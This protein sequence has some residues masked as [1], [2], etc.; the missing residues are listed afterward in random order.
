MWNYQS[1]PLVLRLIC[2]SQSLGPAPDVPEKILQTFPGAGSGHLRWRF[3]HFG[4]SLGQSCWGAVHAE[5]KTGSTGS[6][7]IFNFLSPQRT[8]LIS[9]SNS[10][11]NWLVFHNFQIDIVAEGPRVTAIACQEDQ[12]GVSWLLTESLQVTSSSVADSLFCDQ[13]SQGQRLWQKNWMERIQTLLLCSL[14]Y[15]FSCSPILRLDRRP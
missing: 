15:P 10:V 2:I 8:T 3:H 12:S 5:I 14:T 13:S 6:G 7:V 9:N 4:S 1:G 11:G